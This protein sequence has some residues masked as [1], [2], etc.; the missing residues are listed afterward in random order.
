MG[1]IRLTATQPTVTVAKL[2]YP[3]VDAQGN[4][5][6]LSAVPTGVDLF[7]KVPADAPRGRQP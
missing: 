5:V 6:D 4:E 1:P 3:L 2:P 7:L